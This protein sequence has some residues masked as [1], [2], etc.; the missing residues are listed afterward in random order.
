MKFRT[1]ILLFLIPLELSAVNFKAADKLIADVIVKRL[2]GKPAPDL[3]I[4]PDTCLFNQDEIDFSKLNACKYYLKETY[5]TEDIDAYLS[6]INKLVSFRIKPVQIPEYS[7][8]LSAEYEEVNSKLYFE[9][10][11]SN[12]QF[13]DYNEA[14]TF[15]KKIDDTLDN[16]SVYHALL[17][18]GL[19][20]FE[21]DNLKK[22]KYYLN[23][24]D[25]ASSQYKYAKYNLALISM[26]SSW[27]SEAEEHLRQAINAFN[28]PVLT[29]ADEQL[30]DRIYLTLGYSQ[31]NRKGF[32]EAKNTFEKISLKSQLKYRALLGIAMS[33]IGLNRLSKAA[34]ILKYIMKETEGN[35]YIDALVVLP[36]VYHHADN[37]KLSVDY[38]N[39]AVDK[40]NS[41]IKNNNKHYSNTD[42]LINYFREQD[43]WV[44]SETER[45][46]L[47]INDIK[48]N[49]SLSGKQKEKLKLAKRT[50]N[51]ELS[52]YYLI[53]IK[54]MT[55]KINDYI[56]QVKYSL[57]VI[58][59]ESVAVNE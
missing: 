17:I 52:Q 58:Y 15:L 54:K 22:A 26:R 38:Y 39:Q 44:A 37:I 34:P 55:S 42:D 1:I 27:W 36:Q 49:L 6:Y 59:D 33:E 14:L 24:I 31:V 40:L 28:T 11:R 57:A 29:E 20:Y 21:K 47:V 46:L 41:Y 3:S 25:R 9:I 30:L 7:K 51:S 50:I 16:D 18:Y 48:N 35:E 53:H 45:R 32:R 23:R 13:G 19:V 56:K 2:E 4:S 8:V 5:V 10:A 12:Y 43:P